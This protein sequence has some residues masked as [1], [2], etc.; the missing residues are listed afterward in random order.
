MRERDFNWKIPN[1]PMGA[2]HAAELPFVF[3][4]FRANEDFIGT[5]KDAAE[6]ERWRKLSGAMQDAWIAFARSGDPNQ[7]RNPDLPQW[8]RY[9]LPDRAT[10]TFDYVN[11][12]VNDPKGDEREWWV[13][14]LF[15]Q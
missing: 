2:A 11:E 15:L 5:P 3:D 13:E 6:A 14:N 10:M 7:A 9:Q 1:S 12:V 4:A 8:P